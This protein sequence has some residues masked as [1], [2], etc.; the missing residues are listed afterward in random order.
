MHLDPITTCAPLLQMI[1]N[2]SNYASGDGPRL[3]EYVYVLCVIA[4]TDVYTQ[5]LAFVYSWAEKQQRTARSW[6][7]RPLLRSVRVAMTDEGNDGVWE[8]YQLRSF[9][10]ELSK[11][12]FCF[13]FKYSFHH[14]TKYVLT[15]NQ[16]G[17]TFMHLRPP[18]LNQDT[19][20]NTHFR[21]WGAQANKT[22]HGNVRSCACVK[23]WFISHTHWTSLPENKTKNHL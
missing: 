13:V 2:V 5:T 15:K 16:K 8:E 19:H 1:P 6:P 20:S 7:P 14:L 4:L 11:K 18:S 22:E 23:N 17:R 21:S 12:N 3:C 9:E 10:W